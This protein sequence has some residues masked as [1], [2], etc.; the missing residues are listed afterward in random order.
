ME[1]YTMGLLMALPLW[2]KVAVIP[3][4]IW[5]AYAAA[6]LFS[7]RS[8]SWIGP[9]D[10]ALLEE[11]LARA[12]GLWPLPKL[13]LLLLSFWGMRRWGGLERRDAGAWSEMGL[14]DRSGLMPSL[15]MVL[16]VVLVSFVKPLAFS[17]YFVV[18]LPS[19]V[20][21]LVP[22]TAPAFQYASMRQIPEYS[23][24]IHTPCAT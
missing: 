4:L 8:G 15:L 6:Y 22:P 19:L 21:P 20:P 12:L 16:G 14:L 24:P 5:I 18:L 23:G 11:T 3:A 9:P 7:S 13:A 2:S 1:G 10:F 17:R